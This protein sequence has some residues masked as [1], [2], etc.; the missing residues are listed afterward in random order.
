MNVDIP[1][2]GANLVPPYTIDEK[3]RTNRQLELKHGTLQR[4][5]NM[6]RVSNAPFPEVRSAA[7]YRWR[8][9]RINTQLFPG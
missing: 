5:W 6:D 9:S 7:K 1:D 3:S 2:V 4:C 8:R